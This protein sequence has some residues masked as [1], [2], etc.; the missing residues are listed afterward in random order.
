MIIF[1]SY[2]YKVMK[3]YIPKIN[4]GDNERM[5][6]ILHSQKGFLQHSFYLRCKE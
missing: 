1:D 5:K 2:S 4:F 6:S 3:V